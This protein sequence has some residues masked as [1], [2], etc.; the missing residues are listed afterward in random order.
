[1]FY[2]LVP[3]SIAEIAHFIAEIIHFLSKHLC[4]FSLLN[5]NHGWKS[6]LW[7]SFILSRKSWLWKSLLLSRKSWLEIIHFWMEKCY[8][9]LLFIFTFQS[10]HVWVF[11]CVTKWM[12]RPGI[13]PGPPALCILFFGRRAFYHWTTDACGKWC[14]YLGSNHVGM[15][16]CCQKR[17]ITMNENYGWMNQ[18]CPSHAGNRTPAAAVKAPNPNH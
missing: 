15:G 14:G 13:E 1:M 4:D 8:D 9:S 6:W 17:Q 2:S 7:K 16:C 11:L 12:H 3:P 18:K 10:E 5:P